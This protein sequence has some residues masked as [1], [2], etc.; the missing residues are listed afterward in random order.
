MLCSCH[1]I[2]QTV[3]MVH[4]PGTGTGWDLPVVSRLDYYEP[5]PEK[6]A[7]SPSLLGGECSSVPTGTVD[8]RTVA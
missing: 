5:V 3:P 1:V 6:A 2:K 7:K 4:V 8:L